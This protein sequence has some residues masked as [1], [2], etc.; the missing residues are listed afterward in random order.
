MTTIQIDEWARRRRR[1]GKDASANKPQI[2]PF[3]H[4]SPVAQVKLTSDGTVDDGPIFELDRDRLVV[5]L[6]QESAGVLAFVIF[7]SLLLPRRVSF[8]SVLLP[9]I[10]L[11]LAIALICLS[12]LRTEIAPYVHTLPSTSRAKRVPMST[13]DPFFLLLSSDMAAFLLSCQ[14]SCD[15]L[16]RMPTHLTS[17]MLKDGVG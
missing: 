2:T 8:L 3:T 5:E 4:P 12:R 9:I 10:R 15:G 16:I 17:F 13:D 1:R 6:H 11:Y 14:H 7:G